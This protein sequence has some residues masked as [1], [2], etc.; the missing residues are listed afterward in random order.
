[1]FVPPA[2]PAQ[3]RVGPPPRR[4]PES[5]LL[6][7]RRAAGGWM[8]V[9]DDGTGAAGLVPRTRSLSESSVPSA[10][11]RPLPSGGA[12]CMDS[13][14]AASTRLRG[15]GISIALAPPRPRGCPAAGAPAFI[16]GCTI[17]CDSIHHTM[18]GGVGAPPLSLLT[19]HTLRAAR[20]VC[21]CRPRGRNAQ[22]EAGRWGRW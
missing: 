2:P 7:L 10:D 16:V 21:A 1:M 4:F 18:A 14:S 9:D 17:C 19:L 5:A 6:K 20:A 13:E 8:E 12:P 15:D 22:T 11:V 3:H